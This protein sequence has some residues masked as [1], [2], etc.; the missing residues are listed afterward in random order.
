MAPTSVNAMPA[1]RMLKPREKSLRRKRPGAGRCLLSFCIERRT[2][3]LARRARV[4]GQNT[5]AALRTTRA[6]ANQ[7]L[8]WSASS[9]VY[10]IGGWHIETL[11]AVTS[12]V[13]KKGSEG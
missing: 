13:A 5:E 2:E 10:R 3:G 9:N 1:N 7:C 11:P 12:V 6:G 8:T 4:C